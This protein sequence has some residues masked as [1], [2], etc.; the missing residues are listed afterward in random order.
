MKTALFLPLL[1][2]LAGWTAD[3]AAQ[4]PYELVGQGL[5]HFRDGEFEKA[6]RA[7][8]DAQEA[9]KTPDLRVA[10]DL[11][12][13]LLAKGDLDQARD[14]LLSAAAARDPSLAASARYNLG[15]LALEETRRKIGPDPAAVEPADRQ[16]VLGGLKEA[17]L[18]FRSCLDI[19]SGHPD[20][21]YNLEVV[22]LFQKQ[23]L[24]LW[25][26]KDKQKQ[27]KEEE[28]IPAL[29]RVMKEQEGLR[30]ASGLL[31]TI[32][33]SPKRL[34]ALRE[35]SARQEELEEEI[36]PIKEKLRKVVQA[37][38]QPLQ[39]QA[40]QTPSAGRLEQMQQVLAALQ[41][42][43]DQAGEAMQDASVRLESGNP[44][45][46]VFSQ[47]EA[48]DRLEDLFEGV[49]GFEAL[50]D[51]TIL[52]QKE[53]LEWGQARDQKRQE[54]PPGQRP[55][56]PLP[57]F[58]DP[59]RMADRQ[60]YVSRRSRGLAGQAEE[61]LKAAHKEDENLEEAFQK[62][63]QNGPEAAKTADEARDPLGSER[64]SQAIP[65]QKKALELLEEI[66][67][68]LPRKNQDDKGDSGKNEQDEKK[69]DQEKK[70]KKDDKNPEKKQDPENRGQGQQRSKPQSISR[71]QAEKF[72]Q[73]AREREQE[74]RRRKAEQLRL[75][76]SVPVA[77]DW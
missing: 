26:E 46:A 55:E 58:P 2:S 20:A 57:V 31:G 7:F 45:H 69:D 71:E 59:G 25:K 3:A 64:F 75:L 53:I 48:V 63:V 65:L 40:G 62:A 12:C 17:A 60:G 22:R 44:D 41:K 66:K 76:G 49:A 72:L 61:R 30:T 36:D 27:Y 23:L 8:A 16:T 73:R 39:G 54:T 10:Y 13:A 38:S 4:E 47:A 37:S 68:L 19:H 24:D 77:K 56:H 33:D 18:R 67:R 6:E 28:L 50:L 42:I 21:R 52:L 74:Y 5:E 32:P 70:D 51:Q 14:S 34:Q 11:G 29:V 15:M 35:V 9:G 43:A 1:L